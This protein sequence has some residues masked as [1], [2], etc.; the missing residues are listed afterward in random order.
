MSHQQVYSHRL[1]SISGEQFQA[2]LDRFNLGTFLSAEPIPFGV[3]GQNVFVTSTAGQYV[4]RGAP[5]FPWQFPT[6]QFIARLL[7]ERTNVPVPWP[8]LID[9]TTDIFGWS[10]ALMP[11]MPG[12]QLMDPA[13]K[14]QLSEEDK[15]SIARALGENL[16][17]MH[18][19]TW[20]FSG[21]YDMASG[22]VQPFQLAQELAWPFPI[23]TPKRASIPQPD[24][25]SYSEVVVARIRAYLRAARQLGGDTTA[26]D[27]EWVETVIAQAS[28]ALDDSFQ[29]CLVM[30]D[31]QPGNVVVSSTNGVWRVSGIFDL[32]QAHFGDGETDLSRTAAMYLDEEP[33]LAKEFVRAYAAQKP[34]RPGSSER[35]AL[36]MLDDRLILWMFFHVQGQR[37]WD[38]H[39]TFRDWAG[40]Y[41]SFASN[42]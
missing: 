18:S 9:A 14:A 4:L 13:V 33:A 34:L 42:L 11:R 15:R 31:Y 32:M 12:L 1:G 2:A 40:R 30:Q 7:H 5:H 26:A 36:Y 39:S 17:R 16:A 37:W 6:E 41:V 29:P 8:Y 20:P 23:E 21:R 24:Q 25:A 28:D 35:L 3:F 10:Y 38:E 19:L 27:S 22:T